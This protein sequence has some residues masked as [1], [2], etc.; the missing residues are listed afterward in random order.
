[1]TSGI[2]YEP[3]VGRIR[4]QADACGQLGSPL[5]LHL[6]HRVADDVLAGGPAAAVLAGHEDDSVASALSLRLMAGVHRLA[7]EGGVP[8]LA[9]CFPSTG[10]SYDPERTWPVVRQ[11]LDE[12]ADELR[13]RL[14][15]APQTNEVGRAAA[16]IGGLLHVL[17]WRP[18]PL[19]L[20]EIGASAG[21]NLHADAYRLQIQ[22]GGGVGPLGSPVVLAD[23]WWGTPPPTGPPLEIVERAGCDTEPL[24]PGTEEGRL[25]LTS[26][27]WPDQIARIERLRGA[28]DVAA[29]SPARVER[30][31]AHDFV[32]RLT[33]VPG[34]TTVVWHS[35]M[36]QYLDG[37]EQ[38]AVLERLYELGATADSDAALAR[39]LLEPRP[40]APGR[41][42]EFL[43]ELRTWPGG[44]HRVLGA[45]H[46]HGVPVTWE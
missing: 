29:R 23:P 30:S 35:V 32:E 38:A 20:F 17:A 45:A 7:L 11:V 1:M 13:A 22:D 44:A 43:V 26:Y 16:L 9:A 19:R 31:R 41:N 33:L 8:D 6:L 5:Y 39:L 36:W 10:G 14:G 34:T 15:Q 42:D 24:D 46:P 4:D 28:I 3:L 18:G 2:A 37:A 27:V 21:L 12:Y 25:R 40:R